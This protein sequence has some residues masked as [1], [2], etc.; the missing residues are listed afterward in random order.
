M[1]RGDILPLADAHLRRV[2][3]KYQRNVEAFADEAIAVLLEHTW[4]GNVRQLHHVVEHAVLNASGHVVTVNDLPDTVRGGLSVGLRTVSDDA[5]DIDQLLAVLSH[6]Q[7]DRG[8]AAA[9]LGISRTT[10]WRRLR[11]SPRPS[12][13]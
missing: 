4:P 11:R 10:L 5:N 12:A 1:R 6:Y 7:G 3:Q 8:R 2:T 9:A 13:D